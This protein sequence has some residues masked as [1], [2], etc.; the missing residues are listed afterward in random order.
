MGDRQSQVRDARLEIVVD[1]GRAPRRDFATR[2]M[3]ELAEALTLEE[4][5]SGH[6]VILLDEPISVLDRAESKSVLRACAN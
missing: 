5:S 6:L 1:P 2:Q 3:V 4:H